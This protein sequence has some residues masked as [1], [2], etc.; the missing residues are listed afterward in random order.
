MDLGNVIRSAKSPHAEE[1]LNL[2]ISKNSPKVNQSRA[3]GDL[4][5]MFKT[6]MNETDTEVDAALP[7]LTLPFFQFL[8]L[9]LHQIYSPFFFI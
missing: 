5:K 2:S 1:I 9:L 8:F 4:N 7:R 6:P 3:H